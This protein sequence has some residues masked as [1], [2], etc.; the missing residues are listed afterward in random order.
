MNIQYLFCAEC[1][2][3]RLLRD[4][5]DG[6]LCEQ[7]LRSAVD[8]SPHFAEA[9][10]IIL[11]IMS[12]VLLWVAVVYLLAGCAYVRPLSEYQHVS[13]ASDGLGGPGFDALSVGVRIRPIDGVTI[14][15]LEGGT[16]YK[17]DGMQEMFTG[18]ITVEF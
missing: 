16:L 12:H 18:R 10:L 8:E 3:E 7:C 11:R 17:V 2:C 9:F 6:P 14:D 5:N 15:L 4:Q 1:G 13:H